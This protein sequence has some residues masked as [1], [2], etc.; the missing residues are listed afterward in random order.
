[1]K[2]RDF[3]QVGAAGLA[4]C[5]SY[6]LLAEQAIVPSIHSGELSIQ[7]I[8]SLMDAGKITSVSLTKRYLKRIEELDPK[9]NSILEINPDALIIAEK[10][11]QARKKDGPISALHGIPILIKGNI[12]TMDRMSSSA[13]SLALAGVFA[14]K[15]AHLVHLLRRAGAVLL[16][17]TNLSEWANFR[18]TRSSSG[19]SSQGGQTHNPYSLDRTP[20]GSSSG[21]GVAA[22]AELCAAA[23]GT[24]TD[25]SVVCPSGINGIVG[26]K[27]TIGLV[28]RSGIIPLSHSQDTAGPMARTVSD[29]ATLL[30]IITGQDEGDQA[31]VNKNHGVDYASFLVPGK[32][33]G[34]RI[35]VASQFLNFHDQVDIAFERAVKDLKEAGA[36]IIDPVTFENTKAMG[37]DEY[38][39]LLY[40]F[41]HDLNNYL[42]ASNAPENVNT[43]AKLIEFNRKNK[44]AVMP[45][46][47]QEIFEMA[48]MKGPL[49]DEAYL[50]ALENCKKF[51]QTEGIDRVIK[52]EN[53]DAIIAP[54]NGPAWKIDLVN[55]DHFLGGSSSMAAVSGYPSITVPMGFVSDL[56]IG[57]S[58]FGKAFSEGRLI[59]LAFSYEQLTKHRKS[60]E[61]KDSVDL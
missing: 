10:M 18:S 1:M 39:V 57:I 32:L 37:D 11:D 8:Q 35:G 36:T 19:W 3:I 5:A 60:P 58:F 43:M 2:R 59:E 15:D 55:G 54:T 26:I 30:T 12:D 34:A 52:E 47:Q 48:Q 20:C 61:Y 27:P 14:K 22:A 44:A 23:I 45:W 25:G 6:Q 33:Q 46:F 13:G 21:S 38:T 29:A 17:K 40:E 31:T 7:E 56:P 51:S 49:T 42:E 53:L 16:G 4:G 24:E 50:K 9:L 41:K 28:S